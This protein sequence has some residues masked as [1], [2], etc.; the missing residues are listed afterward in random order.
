MTGAELRAIRERERLS[1]P[2]LA[3]LAGLHPDSLKYWE[4]KITIDLHGHAPQKMLKALGAGHHL[5]NRDFNA[6]DFCALTRARGGVLGKAGI[7]S[8]PKACGA[9]TRKGT[10][11]RAMA[12]NGKG[13][14]K[15]HGGMS[16]G[17]RTPE[18]RKRIA[19]A[20]RRR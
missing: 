6:G 10:I 18:G 4:S 2:A 9:V 12:I 13:R 20:Q 11:C 3:E 5:V 1:R 17:P 14:C 19:D 8:G 15:F 7:L 16:T